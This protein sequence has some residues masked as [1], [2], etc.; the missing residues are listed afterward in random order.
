M[1]K[2]F[3]T[4]RTLV[5]FG[6]LVLMVA[7]AVVGQSSQ[8]AGASTS[9]PGAID[10]LPGLAAVR[11]AIVKAEGVETLNQNLVPQLQAEPNSR[12]VDPCASEPG[13]ANDSP[14]AVACT[15]GD[16]SAVQVMVLYGDSY[17]EQ[18]LPAFDA[19]GKQYHFKVVAYVR[20]GCPFAEV[21]ARDY[22]N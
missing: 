19:L 6:V 13:Q 21:T 7:L 5:S 11:A 12:F 8:R 15:F 9:G 20:Y 17:V 14:A 16:S 3:W 10:E 18:W 4:A 22:F 2:K 1:R